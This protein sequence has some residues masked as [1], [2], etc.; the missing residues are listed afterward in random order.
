MRNL[1]YVPVIHTEPDLGSE[2]SAI[3]S[4]SASLIGEE[5]WARHKK[6]SARFWESIADYFT[7]FD[8]SSILYALFTDD[9]LVSA[10]NSDTMFKN[11]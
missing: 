10:R 3:D 1:L 11:K 5:R 7:N 6:I 2:A 9:S 8:T 4:K